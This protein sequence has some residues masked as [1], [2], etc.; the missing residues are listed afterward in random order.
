MASNEEKLQKKLKNIGP[1][2]A[3]KLVNAG[4]DSPGKLRRMGAKK[5][6]LEMHKK[7]QFCGKYH[8]AYLYALEGAIRDTDWRAI[9]ETLK[10]EYK[11]YAA[12]LRRS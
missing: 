7:G 11:E 12:K 3:K 10:K 9:P 5:V 6:F 8:A 2:M 1:A 4:I